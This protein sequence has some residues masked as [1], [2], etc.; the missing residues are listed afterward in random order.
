[1]K[2]KINIEGIVNTIASKSIQM[3]DPVKINPEELAG[4]EWK[5]E[6]LHQDEKSTLVPKKSLIYEGLDGTQSLRFTHFVKEDLIMM[7]IAIHI[8]NITL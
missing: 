4:L 8:L 1:M 2:Y 6:D 5:L 7:R 3:I